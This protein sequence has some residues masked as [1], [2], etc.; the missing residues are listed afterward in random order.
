MPKARDEKIK[1]TASFLNSI[2]GACVT[3]GILGPLIAV[4][5]N[6]GDAQTKVPP[7]ALIANCL[8]WSASAYAMHYAAR[9]M[10]DDL[11]I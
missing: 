3:V 6:L 8:F 9:K 10:L 4:F 7:W 11:D 2:A 5:L 1:L